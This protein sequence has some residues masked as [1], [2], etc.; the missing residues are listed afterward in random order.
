MASIEKYDVALSFAGEDRDKVRE[1]ANMLQSAGYNVFFDEFKKAE[2]WGEDLSVKLQ[3]VYKEEARFCVMFVSEHYAKKSWTNH[4]RQAALSRTFR[5]QS[6][7]LLPIRLDDTDLPG[8]PDVIAYLD[9]R[10]IQVTEVF[11][12][13]SQKLGK[14][15]ST[16]REPIKGQSTQVA[17]DRVRE[18]LATCYR[19]AIFTRV[20][21]QLSGEA[22]FESLA[23]CRVSLQKIVVFVEPEEL[24]RLVAGIIAELDF[25]ERRRPQNVRGI[26][27]WEPFGAEARQINASKL[28]IIASLFQ[29]SK[30]AGVSFVMPVSTTDEMF[31][32]K[33]DADMPPGKILSPPPT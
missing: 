2:L 10:S 21:C 5:E 30:A 20:H 4:E 9:L 32:S 18:V 26:Y 24:Q 12:L 33:E 15:F 11:T 27:N 19:R 31:W 29:L 3:R 16:S 22:M 6:A 23:E 14:P 1:L 28:R 25:L 13:L 7:Y 8:L 17:V